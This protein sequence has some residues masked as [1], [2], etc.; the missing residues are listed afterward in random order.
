MSLLKKSANRKSSDSRDQLTTESDL[1]EK[2]RER[3]RAYQKEQRERHL[4]DWKSEKESIDSMSV[5]QL[6]EYIDETTENSADPRV[7]LH[8]M[9]INP[10]ELAIIK[11]AV[12][13]SGARSSREL[14]VK[15]CKEVI[16]NSTY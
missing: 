7:G 2:Q 4:S 15:H 12:N 9:K 16:K 13:L 1:L 8:S 5:A 3:T 11:L 14:F 6:R 10:H